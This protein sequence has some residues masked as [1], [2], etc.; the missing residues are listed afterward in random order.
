[1]QRIFRSMGLQV[2]V[3][4][5]LCCGSA[6]AQTITG[7]ITG[8]V[9]DASGAVISGAKV[10]ATNVDTNVSVSATTNSTGTYSL[11]FLQ[12]GRYKVLIEDPGF[13]SQSVAP[14]SL[15]VAQ[16][17]KIDGKLSAGTAATV[18][19]SDNLAPIL[20]T[21]DST[22]ATT[23]TANTIENIPLNG[24]NW[25]SLTLFLPGATSTNP[26]SFGGAGNGNAIERNQNG[27]GNSQ[28]NIN[29]NR[30]EGNNYLLDGIEINETLNNLVG[31]NP[32]P[33]AL[34]E[35]RVISANAPAEYGNVNGG[36]VLAI[37]KSGTNQFHGSVGAFLEDY[38]LDANTWG[39]K[40]FPPTIDP[41]TKAVIPPVITPRNP[42][43]QTQ[44]S[45]TIGGP[46]IKDKLF[47]F[48]DYFG[49]RY[50]EG[51]QTTSSVL[52]ALMRQGDFSELL[53]PAIVGAGNTIQLYDPTNNYAPYAGNKGVPI[54]NP[55]AKYLIAHPEIYPLPNVAP[56]TNSAVSNNFRGNTQHVI[57]N[58]Q[59]DIKIDWTPTKKGRSHFRTVPAG[60]SGRYK[61]QSAG[62]LLSGCQQLSGQGYCDQTMSGRLAHQS[63]MS[64]A[65]VS[66]GF[67]GYRE[68]PTIRRGSSALAAIPRWESPALRPSRALARRT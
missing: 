34:G 10:T 36:D 14:F 55:V 68:I 59:G 5:V 4:A 31:Y 41:V 13:A 39:N 25:S 53:N 54:N 40:N 22:V 8:T 35:V 12:V 60:R 65:R 17:A 6:F 29:G 20:N 62:G 56:G 28:A 26:S 66:R 63:S 32:N 48:A 23:L 9:T 2:G 47:F 64:S 16:V 38:K 37:T 42:Y 30:A 44:Y 24:R 43:T 7:D 57:F 11:R 45:A 1:M 19:V 52:T 67:A 33:D 51:G 3:A 61:H 49:T 50:H 46:I 58:N 27:G 21:E 18:D 15:E